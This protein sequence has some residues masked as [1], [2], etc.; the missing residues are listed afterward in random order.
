VNC[1]G[2]PVALFDERRRGYRDDVLSP[3]VIVRVVA[4]VSG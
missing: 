2:F 1:A 3:S 4:G